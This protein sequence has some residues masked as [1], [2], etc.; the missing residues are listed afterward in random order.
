MLAFFTYALARMV[1][2]TRK[3]EKVQSVEVI[4][5]AAVSQAVD[6]DMVSLI[7][8]ASKQLES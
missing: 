5:V 2:Y 1:R 6:A 8:I 3:Q 4:T 7:R